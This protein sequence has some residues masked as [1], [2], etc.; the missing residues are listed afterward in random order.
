MVSA[1]FV[2]DRLSFGLDEREVAGCV[3][4]TDA[5]G[6]FAGEDVVFGMGGVGSGRGVV[7]SAVFERRVVAF[8][9]DPLPDDPTISQ[10]KGLNPNCEILTCSWRAVVVRRDGR[11][12]WGHARECGA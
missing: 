10:M 11:Y 5:A 1:Y 3:G 12:S 7:V 8:N 6:D 4:S 2:R 9:L